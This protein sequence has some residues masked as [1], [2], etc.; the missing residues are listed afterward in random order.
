MIDT[1]PNNDVCNIEKLPSIYADLKLSGNVLEFGTFTGRSAIFLA[2]AFS[3][4]SIYTIDHFQGLEQS[5]KTPIQDWYEGAF[6]LGRD[7]YKDINN[8]PKSVMELRQRIAP[9]TNI[10]LIEEDIHKLELPYSYGIGKIG[11]VNVDVDI[12]EPTVSALEFLTKCEWDNIFIRFDDWHG[13][14][15]EYYE[16]ERLAFVEWIEKYSYDYEI[17]HGGYIGGVHVKR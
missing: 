8:V 14:E 7:E 16:H 3:D 9:H 15:P 10:Q 4:K 1:N 11:L 13:T 5:T 6:A 12:Y 2:E 17:T